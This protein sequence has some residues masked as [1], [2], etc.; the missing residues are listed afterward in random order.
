MIVWA[1]QQMGDHILCNGLYRALAE[2]HGKLSVCCI[3][4]NFANVSLMLADDRR[5]TVEPFPDETAIHKAFDAANGETVIKVGSHGPQPFD[6][7]TFDREFY[8][9]ANV[10]F[11]FRWSKCLLPLLPQIAPPQ[12]PYVFVHDRPEMGSKINLV[13]QRIVRPVPNQPIFSHR[14]LI[15]HAKELHCVSSAFAT[16]ADSLQLK[17]KPFHFYPFG[18]EVPAS[19]N[20]RI[21]HQ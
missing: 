2:R 6:R 8:R 16:F 15:Y 10:P 1:H 12:G 11:E 4:Q 18:R 7:W 17:G 19:Q 14:S 5:I 9:Q 3:F 13:G 21:M 20:P